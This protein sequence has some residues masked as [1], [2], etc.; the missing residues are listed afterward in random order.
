MYS[1]GKRTLIARAAPCD[2]S[3]PSEPDLLTTEGS[4]ASN[5]IRMSYRPELERWS[6]STTKDIDTFSRRPSC[7]AST[8][9]NKPLTPR[10]SACC[11]SFLVTARSLFTYL[12]QDEEFAPPD[13]FWGVRLLTIGKIELGRAALRRRFR[14]MNMMPKW[15]SIWPT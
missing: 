14:R 1:I 12:E 9:M 8:V 2:R 7:G 13:I 4:S 11:T 15:G 5:F 6:T 10:L 3:T